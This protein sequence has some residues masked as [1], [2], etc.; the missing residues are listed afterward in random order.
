MKAINE[1]K[2]VINTMYKSFDSETRGI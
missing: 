1:S 2:E